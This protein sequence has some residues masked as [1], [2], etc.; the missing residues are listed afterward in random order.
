MKRRILIG[1]ALLLL[2]A[3]PLAGGAWRGF[4]A[5][6]GSFPPLVTLPPVHTAFSWPVFILFA[7]LAFLAAVILCVGFRPPR[8]C[9]A[10]ESVPSPPPHPYPL[11]GRLGLGLLLGSWFLAWSRL[12]LPGPAEQHTFFPLWLGFVFVLDG[13]AYRR[14]GRSLFA[15]RRTAFLLSFPV[16]ALS[17]WYFEFLNRF[18]QNW[19]YPDRLDFGP[20][21]YLVYSSLCFS[22]VLP[23]VFETHALL[24]TIPGLR[25]RWSNGPR[26]RIPR[27]AALFFALGAVLLPLIPLFPDPLFFAVWVTPLALLA[28]ALGLAGVESPFDPIRNGDWTPVVSLA[29]AALICGFFWELWNAGSTPR[30]AYAVPY[31]DRFHLFAMPAVGYAGYLPFGPVCACFWLAWTALLPEQG[32][33]AALRD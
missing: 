12:D 19:W 24:R 22:T 18:V 27:A 31:V 15:N 21:H 9:G 5:G 13:L 17:W 23:A 25:R 14:A 8:P 29:L 4:P 11:H 26:L 2:A 3:L 20:V 16:S 10:G 33:A 1:L 7:A 32:R 6:F 28:G 30:W